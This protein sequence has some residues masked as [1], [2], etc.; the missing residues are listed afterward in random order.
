MTHLLA[1]EKH[2]AYIFALASPHSDAPIAPD[3][4]SRT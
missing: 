1:S 3:F 2:D 4:L